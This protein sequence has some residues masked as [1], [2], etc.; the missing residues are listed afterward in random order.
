MKSQITLNKPS[1]KSFPTPVS[2]LDVTTGAAG[3]HIGNPETAASLFKPAKANNAIYVMSSGGS[4]I[5]PHVPGGA[6]SQQEVHPKAASVRAGQSVEPLSTS[7][8]VMSAPH[9]S[10]KSLSPLVK[11]TPPASASSLNISSQQCNAIASGPAA[12]CQPKQE[13]EATKVIKGP[14]LISG[15]G[16]LSKERVQQNGKCTST[17]D[18]GE[19]V[20]GQKAN[21]EPK[22]KNMN[23]AQHPNENLMADDNPVDVT[24]CATE[25]NQNAYQLDIAEHPNKK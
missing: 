23:I 18:L 14:N 4:S 16:S 15:S 12:E 25:K 19:G 17:D 22:V 20:K 13:L 11:N 24:A 1:A 3:A 2:I 5:K 9:S 6:F 10:V 8:Y 7:S 21:L